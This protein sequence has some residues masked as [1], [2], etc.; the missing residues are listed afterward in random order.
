MCVCVTP[1][2]QQAIG[3]PTDDVRCIDSVH[4]GIAVAYFVG[5][6]LMGILIVFAACGFQHDSDCFETV[7]DDVLADLVRMPDSSVHRDIH[8]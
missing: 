6:W 3:V 4:V 8:A 7:F 5:M 2:S 1:D